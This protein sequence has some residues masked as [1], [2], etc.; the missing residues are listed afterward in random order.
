MW[1][2]A[3]ESRSM[4]DFNLIPLQFN[5]VAGFFLWVTC[6]AKQRRDCDFSLRVQ[7]QFIGESRLRRD[8]VGRCQ[9]ACKS[10]KGAKAIFILKTPSN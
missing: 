7:S 1:V 5:L 2:T 6:P 4:P 10:S 9:L 3:W 8:N